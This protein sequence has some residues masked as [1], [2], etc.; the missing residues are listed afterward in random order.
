MNVGDAVV[1]QIISRSD[2][3]TIKKLTKAHIWPQQYV[4]KKTY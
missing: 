1:T 4:R 3:T 2:K